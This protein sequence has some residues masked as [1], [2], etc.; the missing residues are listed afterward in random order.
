LELE[1]TIPEEMMGFLD[2]WILLSNIVSNIAEHNRK[3]LDIVE[4]GPMAV[5][6]GSIAFC[7]HSTIVGRL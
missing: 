6:L 4:Q 7:L 3:L 2:N 1:P 5:H